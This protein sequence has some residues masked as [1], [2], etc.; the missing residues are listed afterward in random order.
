MERP[1]VAYRR[2]DSASF[3]E[4]PEGSADSARRLFQTVHERAMDL[5]DIAEIVLR[6][7]D[8]VVDR[9]VDDSEI[10]QTVHYVNLTVCGRDVHSWHE[11]YEAVRDALCTHLGQFIHDDDQAEEG[12]LCDGIER[13]GRVLRDVVRDR[14]TGSY[15]GPVHLQD[16]WQHRG[17][18]EEPS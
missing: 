6:E 4:C 7:G 15:C 9:W 14:E 5:G 10:V 8:H 18:D 16:F 13:L 11:S 12:I 2:K 3:V 17:G 1:S